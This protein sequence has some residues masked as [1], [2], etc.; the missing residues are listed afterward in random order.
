MTDDGRDLLTKIGHETSLR[1]AIQLITAASIVAQQR[2]ATQVSWQPLTCEGAGLGAVVLHLRLPVVRTVLR[3]SGCFLPARSSHS[4]AAWACDSTPC[5]VPAPSGPS[6][7]AQPTRLPPALTVPQPY[8]T[9]PQVDVE[10][11]GRVYSLLVD[12][13]RSTQFLIEYQEQYMFNEVPEAGGAE[14]GGGAEGMELSG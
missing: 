5:V 4:A 11:I 10:D 2:K 8:R 6:A 12:V 14:E 9:V 13:K 3:C 1:Y 7:I